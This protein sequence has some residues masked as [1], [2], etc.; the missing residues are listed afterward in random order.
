M[1]LD[2]LRELG[3]NYDPYAA[4]G[5]ESPAG[6]DEI[7]PVLIAACADTK[8]M[9]SSAVK[10]KL[11]ADIRASLYVLVHGFGSILK[12]PIASLKRGG[13]AT[14]DIFAAQVLTLTHKNE[15]GY[16][17]LQESRSH[18]IVFC[19]IFLVAKG[20]GV[21]RF[22]FDGRRLNAEAVTPPPVSLPNMHDFLKK[23]NTF[24]GEC[25][26]FV[27]FDYRH[28]FHQLALPPD[29]RDCIGVKLRDPDTGRTRY[30]SYTTLPMGFS[31][32]P[33]IA[34]ACAW[35]TVLH[36]EDSAPKLFRWDEKSDRISSF[37]PCISENS[38]GVVSETGFV[39]IM[40][41]NIIIVRQGSDVTETRKYAQRI[42]S[43]CANFKVVIKEGS[44]Y[45]PKSAGAGMD[46]YKLIDDCKPVP[47]KRLRSG[48][49]V[50]HDE[51]LPEILGVEF[52][53]S[54]QHKQRWR[55]TQKRIDRAE[56]YLAQDGCEKW[57]P[58]E[59]AARVGLIVWNHVVKQ[60]RLGNIA[61]LFE[62]LKH[63][64]ISTKADWDKERP[65]PDAAW[66]AQVREELTAIKLNQWTTCAPLKL[67]PLLLG[68]SDASDT[69]LGGV[70]FGEE[71]EPEA[72]FQQNC[73]K[74]VHIFIKEALAAQRLVSHMLQTAP[75]SSTIRILIDNTACR[76]AFEKG[77]STN[78]EVN[79][80]IVRVWN[81][82][83]EREVDLQF[84]DVSTDLNIADCLTIDS[85]KRRCEHKHADGK[86]C[87]ERVSASLQV[88]LL[89]RSGRTKTVT[90]A[91]AQP[92]SKERLAFT[93]F[94]DHTEVVE[95][96][97]WS[98]KLQQQ[99]ELD[100]PS[101]GDEDDEE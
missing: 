81:E 43:N 87:K 71:D 29:I 7:D 78:S 56:A 26:S 17:I 41:D 18:K 69:L 64:D 72:V 46:R 58:R 36:R 6:Q 25:C 90:V 70:V 66:I 3:I 93:G 57:T 14:K 86:F 55:H 101:D 12:T 83:D 98:V 28:W 54:T 63:F 2:L 23:L 60:K 35:A 38:E 50:P 91:V 9:Y 82:A 59:I 99:V 85:T 30:F 79:K 53:S 24:G 100:A 15:S 92:I 76:R 95:G 22:I 73:R 67:G 19:P 44:M 21:A 61:P 51:L 97:D 8:A 4:Y 49:I 80:L 27:L 37:V 52:E 84:V 33:A 16:S 65:A 5:T 48:A 20:G 11:P 13:P 39:T 62:Q 94:C 77:Y 68:A 88:L 32:S 45:I 89:R 74:G 42:I 34:E 96:H 47:P 40:Y 75:M 1:L 10:H 31:H